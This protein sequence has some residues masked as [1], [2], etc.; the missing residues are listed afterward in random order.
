[1]NRTSA[2][3]LVVLFCC[4]AVLALARHLAATLQKHRT[5]GFSRD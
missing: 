2:L 1:M 3:I 4:G 5:Q